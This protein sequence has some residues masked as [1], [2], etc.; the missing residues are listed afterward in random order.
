MPNTLAHLGLHALATRGVIRDAP[1]GWIWLGCVLPDLPWIFQRV[2]RAVPLDLSPIDI[3]LH[4]IVQSSLL[5]CL[6]GPAAFALLAARP[7][8]VFAILALGS[9]LHLLLD[10]TQT[11][12]GN[13]VILAAP[14]DWQV[15]NFGL[16]WPEHGVT[17]A[18]TGL[19]LAWFVWA[20]VKPGAVIQ[21]RLPVRRRI[22]LAVPLAAIWLIGPVAFWSAAERADAH[23]TGTLRA[24]ETR[25][26]RT[27]AFDRAGVTRDSG[28]ARLRVWTG[29]TF[30]V[31]GMALPDGAE[32]VSVQGRFATPDT[33]LIT[34]LHVHAKG[35]RDLMSYLGLALVGAWWLLAGLNVWRG[36]H[37]GAQLR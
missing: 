11:K 7:G 2:L 13:G 8:R 12:W 18:L 29:E 27:I 23:F 14:V 10:A 24:V 25:E 16:Y 26:A 22:G 19:G 5:F 31:T 37:R 3:R 20:A 9:A 21:A 35:W 30:A 33:V 1:Y 17:L 36:R 15:T 6:I 28:D 34:A 4:A 32:T